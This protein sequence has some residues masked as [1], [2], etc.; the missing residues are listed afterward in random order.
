MRNLLLFFIRNYYFFLFLFLEILSFSFLIRNNHFQRSQLINSSNVV[1]GNVLGTYSEITDYFALK[2]VNKNLSVENSYLRNQLRQ[3]FMDFSSYP[4]PEKDSAL[5]RQYQF[6][7]AKVINNSTQRKKNYLTLNRGSKQGIKP[8]MGVICGSGIV[9]IV[10]N[11]SENFSSVMSL[12]NEDSRVP[13]TIKK[14]GENSILNW[15]GS[16]GT[17]GKMERIPSY[18]QIKKNDTIVTSSYSAVFPAVI[19][20]GTVEEFQKI[21]GN[22]FFDVTVKFSTHFNQLSY[23]YVVNNFLREEQI[24]IEKTLQQ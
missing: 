17:I 4:V 21:A 20:V 10:R 1:V 7:V 8:G 11:V 15:D 19:M 5:R 14:F 6:V 3:S 2:E 12:L 23:V 24:K 13:V 9:G 16:D 22:T 18:L